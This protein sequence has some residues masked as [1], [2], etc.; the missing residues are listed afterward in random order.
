[1]SQWPN[2][3][4]FPLLKFD[5]N[6]ARD[7]YRVSAAFPF[8]VHPEA[9]EVPD[10]SLFFIWMKS[11]VTCQSKQNRPFV[12]YWSYSAANTI[13]LV[14]MTKN[15]RLNNQNRL[16]QCI[17]YARTTIVSILSTSKE[18]CGSKKGQNL[19]SSLEATLLESNSIYW[20][21]PIQSRGDISDVFWY[22]E[23]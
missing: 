19:A 15:V 21:A 3:D 18:L 1:M 16:H 2:S 13:F 10:M 12:W 9:R 5:F 17:L 4:T 14:H 11:L 7:A 20:R 23:K 6:F 22:G 8:Q